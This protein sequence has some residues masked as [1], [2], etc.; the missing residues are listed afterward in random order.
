MADGELGTFAE[1][2]W[3]VNTT[4][5]AEELSL[6]P[7]RRYVD[8]PVGV[9]LVLVVAI[10]VLVE[11]IFELG[12]PL[13]LLVAAAVMLVILLVAN[14]VRSRHRHRAQDLLIEQ[15]VG[16]TGARKATR[17]LVKVKEWG[18]GFLASPKV[19]A[20]S[21]APRVDTTDPKWRMEVLQI[22]RR[23]VP[24]QDASISEEKPGR[25]RVTFSDP[26]KDEEKAPI[27]GA[28]ERVRSIGRELLGEGAEVVVDGDPEEPTCL[29][30][31][32]ELGTKMAFGSR[33][34]AVERVIKARIP[35]AWEP[36]W[37][38]VNDV[39]VF[40]R[41]LP[42]PGLL[43]PPAE[44]MPV[45]TTH[46]EYADWKV[47]YGQAENEEE[48]YWHPRKQAHML[49]TGPTGSGKTVLLHR[50]V[51]A[52]AQAGWKIHIIDGKRIEFLG[53]RGWPNVELLGAKVFHQMRMVYETHRLMEER[54]SMIENGEASLEDFEPLLL[55]IDEV[56]TFLKRV[57]RVWK[58]IK[59]KGAPAK[60]P[61]LDLI[62]DMARLSRSAKIH[63][64]IGLQ[65]PDVEFL[66]GEMRDNFGARASLGRMSVNGA[67]MMWE[68]PGIGTNIPRGMPGR[69]YSSTLDGR[70]LETQFYLV[71]NPDPT[72]VGFDA[73]ET[74]AVRPTTTIWP[75]HHVE[76]LE[77]ET[78]GLD[79][80]EVPLLYDDY[81]EARILPGP[82]PLWKPLTARSNT[83]DEA[84]AAPISYAP[85]EPEEPVEEEFVD[86]DS[87]GFQSETF[88]VTAAQVEIGDL[89][90]VEADLEIWGIVENLEHENTGVMIDFRSLDTGEP[91]SLTLDDNSTVRVRKPEADQEEQ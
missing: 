40:T 56:A 90:E 3:G 76:D 14:G 81:M 82:S 60:A 57:D 65:R 89:V 43:V 21:V 84:E 79:D 23:A 35:G 86:P 8:V 20:L 22:L 2:I 6:L 50:V 53:F 52:A 67:Q 1:P 41:K 62:A 13:P 27:E 42:L 64:L 39:V 91:E 78:T 29:T 16:K 11:K 18:H 58:S 10:A 30:I 68:H 63:L 37:D 66:S 77:P 59:P 33:R 73:E 49:V 15:L 54:Y 25:I 51:Q 19:L 46:A 7:P 45:I 83:G 36:K 61:V 31:K 48:I 80:E 88:T 44:H 69:G 85:E 55:V 24:D 32:H 26:G 5:D 38:L 9:L 12:L 71:P 34:L 17:A 28:E 72:S 75:I 74:A 87:D 70:I 47:V 4:T